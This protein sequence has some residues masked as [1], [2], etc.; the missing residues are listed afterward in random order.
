MTVAINGVDKQGVYID[1]VQV[2][3][4]LNA[5]N[6]TVNRGIYDP[7]T[8]SAVDADLAVGNIKEAITIFGKLGTLVPGGALSEDFTDQDDAGNANVG[9]IGTL[10]YRNSPEIGPGPDEGVLLTMNKTFAAGAYAVAVGTC[11]ASINNVAREATLRLYMGGVMV[12]E[13]AMWSLEIDYKSVIGARALTGS[14]DCEIRMY[15]SNDYTTP[16]LGGPQGKPTIVE[17]FVGS[18][19]P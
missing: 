2:K 3:Q 1:G 5:A 11:L 6:E 8:L 9:Q 12:A 14:Q 15:I 10:Y 18:I 17:V 7:T 19:K 13:S 4:A 16:K